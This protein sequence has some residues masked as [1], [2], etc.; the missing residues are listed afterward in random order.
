MRQRL[1]ENGAALSPKVRRALPDWATHYIVS[2]RHLYVFDDEDTA[3]RHPI[4][5]DDQSTVQ[6]L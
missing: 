4:A 6:S 2:D 1:I 5:Q 3:R